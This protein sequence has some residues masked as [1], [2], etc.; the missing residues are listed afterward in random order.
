[1]SNHWAFYR[2]PRSHGGR[3]VRASDS[4]TSVSSS[5]PTSAIIYDAYTYILKIKKITSEDK[6]PNAIFTNFDKAY[7]FWNFHFVISPEFHGISKL[8]QCQ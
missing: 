4:E 5:M 8:S 7:I 3:V 1:M 6:C 2:A